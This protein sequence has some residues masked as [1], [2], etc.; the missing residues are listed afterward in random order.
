MLDMIS[1]AAGRARL[2]LCE[3]ALR[4]GFARGVAAGDE[5]VG[6]FLRAAAGAERHLAVLHVELLLELLLDAGEALEQLLA[7]SDRICERCGVEC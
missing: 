7:G 6:G 2:A 5:D 4:A 3:E 1:A